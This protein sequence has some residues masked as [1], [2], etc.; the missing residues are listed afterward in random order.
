MRQPEVAKTVIEQAF[1]NARADE[2]T[3]AGDENRIVRIDDG[4]HLAGC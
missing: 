1:D 3:G 4:V 2:S